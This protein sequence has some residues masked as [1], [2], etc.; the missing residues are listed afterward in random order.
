MDDS[1]TA[2]N[3]SKWVRARE[4]ERESYSHFASMLQYTLLARVKCPQSVKTHEFTGPTAE[5][6]KSVRRALLSLWVH[7]GQFSSFFLLFLFSWSNFLSHWPFF[8][9]FKCYINVASEDQLQSEFSL[10][11]A[12][13]EGQ[14]ERER[15]RGKCLRSTKET[16]CKLLQGDK[17]SSEMEVQKHKKTVNDFP[18]PSHSQPNF[19]R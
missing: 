1:L 7:L 18:R 10:S 15:D 16:S 4:R 12:T 9:D 5:R 13:Q 11:H 8:D 19:P 17:G 6:E 3:I 2:Y 14:R